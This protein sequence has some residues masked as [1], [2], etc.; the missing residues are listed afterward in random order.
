MSLANFIPTVW[1]ANIL[2]NLN[3]QHVYA[4]PGIVNRDYEGQ[5]SAFGDTVKINSFGR[6]STFDYTKNTN[7]PDPEVLT[8]SQ[9][10][11]SITEARAFNFYIDD[12]DKAQAQPALMGPA[13]A[14]ASYSLAEDA[15]QFVGAMYVDG[16][17]PLT[18]TAG[19]PIELT[20]ADA[21]DLLVELGIKLKGQRIV[22]DKTAVIPEW[23]GGLVAKDP[24]FLAGSEGQQVLRT[25]F[26]GRVANTTLVES[27]NVP[28]VGSG[29]SKGWALQVSTPAAR[30]Y[31]EQIV[32]T[33][34]YRPEKRFGDALKGLHVYGGKVI[35]PEAL[36]TAIVRPASG[37]F[38]AGV[39]A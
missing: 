2:A 1:S 15:D 39:V 32:Q 14:E 23:F 6:V 33:E 10:T 24:R 29:T 31:V 38:R 3:K 7:L 28:T 27:A 19:A 25:G 5:I 16:T 8:S 11:L 18:G 21:Y 35:R 30:S 13:T 22:G 9:R 20:P 26:A 36:V 12:I 17:P 37:T 4:Q 34:G